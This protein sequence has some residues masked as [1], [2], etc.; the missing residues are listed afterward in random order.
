MKSRWVEVIEQIT[1]PVSMQAR[2]DIG[3]DYYIVSS[4]TRP[5]VDWPMDHTINS[6]EME[7]IN[8][9]YGK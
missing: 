4:S 9:S 5:D 1:D 2:K 3:D 8:K 6:I 7:T